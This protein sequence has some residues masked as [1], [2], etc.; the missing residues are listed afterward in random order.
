MDTVARWVDVIDV[1]SA[2]HYV[3]P[4]DGKLSHMGLRV[5]KHIAYESLGLSCVFPLVFFVLV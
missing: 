2:I 4:S 3:I 5:S 1:M